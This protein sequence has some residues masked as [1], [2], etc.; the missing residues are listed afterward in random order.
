MTRP[1]WAKVQF[2]GERKDEVL[3]GTIWYDDSMHG[4]VQGGKG[5]L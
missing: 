3:R 5:L 1:V 2:F 4:I